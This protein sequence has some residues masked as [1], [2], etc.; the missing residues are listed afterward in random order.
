MELGKLVVVHALLLCVFS[1]LTRA[2]SIE[3]E[4]TKENMLESVLSYSNEISEG[5]DKIDLNTASIGDL[6][7]IPGMSSKFAASIIEYR[8]KVKFIHSIGELSSLDGATPTMISVLKNR[9]VISEKERLRGSVSSYLSLS[10]QKV[11]LYREAC[12]ESGLRNFQKLSLSY[13]NFEFHAITDKDAGEKNYLDFCSLAFSARNVSVFSSVIVGDYDIGLG[14][15]M[16]FSNPGNISKSAGP[17]SPLFSRDAYTLRPYRSRAENGNLRGAALAIPIGDL[18]L[19][20]FASNKN[21]SAHMDTSG[22]VT[23]IDYSGMNLHTPGSAALQRLNE[24]IVGGVVRYEAPWSVC[25]LSAIYFSYDRPFSRYYLDRH[26]VVDM[27]LRSQLDNV[28]FSGEAMADKVV[29]FSTNIDLDYE[30]ARFAMGVREL[31]SRIV[32]NYSGVLAESFPTGPEE[33]IYFG[34]VFRPVEI[35]KLG[36]YY[37]RFRVRSVSGEPDRN[38]EEIYADSYIWLTR[39]E[40]SKGSGSILYLK[41]RYKTKEDF[42]VP[43]SDLPTAQSTLAGSKQNLRIDLRH[44]FLPA[45]SVRARFEKNFLP[46]GESGELFLFD[47]SWKFLPNAAGTIDSRICFCRT[48]SFNTAFYEVEDDLQGVAQYSLLYGDCARIALLISLKITSPLTLGAKISRDLFG[49]SRE[50]T[51]GSASLLL[52]GITYLSVEINYSFL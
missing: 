2:Q 36:F 7:S 34:A 25:G 14:N 31:R 20:G 22:A 28:A 4:I 48:G 44:R 40:G 9:A 38:G 5:L 35:V 26:F 3:D 10:P 43:D 24:R 11:V 17:V 42:Y 16:M 33:G 18:E 19:T 32:P 1:E 37:D 51:I 52:P 50:I 27:F 41:Y 45:F 15:G 49:G 46:S 13:R 30:G 12:E 23:S 47:A 21:F 29:S 6:L 8:G 39:Y